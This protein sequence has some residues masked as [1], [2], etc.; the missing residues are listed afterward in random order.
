M[1]HVEHSPFLQVDVNPIKLHACVTSSVD[2]KLRFFDLKKGRLELCYDPMAPGAAFDV[3]VTR[4]S[5]APMQ[6]QAQS[7]W[8]KHLRYNTSHDQLLLTG[9]TATFMNLYRFQSISSAPQIMF[10]S[11]YKEKASAVE[12]QGP[13]DL[14][15]E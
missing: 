1:Q 7:H 14:P 10:G 11:G 3:P 12:E 5:S 9:D 15:D 6:P 13:Y 4:N 2:A 8:C